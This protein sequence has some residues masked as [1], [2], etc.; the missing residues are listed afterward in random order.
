MDKKGINIGDPTPPRY[1]FRT[2]GH[3]FKRQLDLME[4]H[5]QPVPDNLKFRIFDEVYIISKNTDIANIKIKNDLLD[6]KKLIKTEKGTEQWESLIKYQFPLDQNTIL[7]E[8]LPLLEADLPILENN[9]Y[10]INGFLSIAK[11]NKDLIP[12]KVHKKRQA[13]L[14][15]YTICEYAEVMIE[16]NILYTISVESID[17]HKVTNTVRQL[18]MGHF[19]NINYVQAIKQI[20]GLR[21][22]SFAN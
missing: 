18:K 13:Y 5:T 4:K 16:N 9:I 19:K 15:N 8:I 14:V 10:D 6:I 11:K 20:K 21:E 22:E 3:D 7:K 12:V 1:E 2:F 17:L